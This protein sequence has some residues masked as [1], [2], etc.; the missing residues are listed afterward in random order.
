MENAEGI[1][2][3]WDVTATRKIFSNRTLVNNSNYD[4]TRGED[5]HNKF[6]LRR[7][8]RA[9]STGNFVNWT[10]LP[11]A[12]RGTGMELILSW[13]Q[14]GLTETVVPMGQTSALADRAT[15]FCSPVASITMT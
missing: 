15:N 9:P 8:E 2:V 10:P 7:L 14:A 11:G 3:R 5:E 4:F 1:T 6:K 13:R 12:V